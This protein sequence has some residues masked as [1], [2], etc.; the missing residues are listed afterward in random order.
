LVIALAVIVGRHVFGAAYGCD[1]EILI[2]EKLLRGIV[3]EAVDVAGATLI[4]IKS[5]RV[6]GEKG[7]VSVIALVSES[8]V[9]I[10]TWPEYGYATIDVYT[11]GEQTEPEKAFHYIVRK[12]GCRHYKYD[13][14]DRSLY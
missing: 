7:G 5:W 6:E 14:A 9:A 11:C 1:R 10:H 2:D 12:L 13:S 3:I 4:D 8:H